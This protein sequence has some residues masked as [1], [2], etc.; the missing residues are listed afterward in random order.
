[1]RLLATLT[2]FGSFLSL[3]SLSAQSLAEHAAAAAGATIGTAAGKPMS[4]AID[5]IFG[6][7][8]EQTK[9]ASRSGIKS[10]PA[11][12]SKPQVAQP[13]SAVPSAPAPETVAEGGSGSTRSATAAE[14]RAPRHHAST[15]RSRQQG[16]TAVFTPPAPPVVVEPPAPKE[17]T[18]EEVAAIKIGANENDVIATLGVPASRVIIP[19][20]DGHLRE[21]FQ[22]WAKGSEVGVVRLDNGYVVKV[23]ARA[24]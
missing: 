18:A 5:K 10:A 11:A 13:S 22:F 1:M 9:T 14:R 2:L 7:T 24:F 4:G 15:H 8:A 3:A 21:T 16:E 23:N 17:P 19:D 20:D 6:K 12:T